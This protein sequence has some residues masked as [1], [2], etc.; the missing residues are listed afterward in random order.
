MVEQLLFH[1]LKNDS[2]V[3]SICL[4]MKFQFRLIENGGLLKANKQG[5][6]AEFYCSKVYLVTL[7]DGSKGL[8][9]DQRSKAHYIAAE[10][11]GT[12]QAPR[13]ER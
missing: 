10:A 1:W 2:P 13:V 6:I 12:S 4:A 9:T 11:D 7:G 3:G 8:L 5:D